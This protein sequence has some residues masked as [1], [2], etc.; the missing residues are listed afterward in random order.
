[1]NLFKWFNYVHIS[2]AIYFVGYSTK[3]VKRHMKKEV[4]FNNINFL[5][6]LKKANLL[7]FMTPSIS[8]LLK[9]KSTI[10]PNPF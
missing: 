7:N 6:K 10:G 9:E 2:K 4:T 5:I 1:M 3:K 8:N